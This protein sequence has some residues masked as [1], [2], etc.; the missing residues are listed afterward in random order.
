MLGALLTL[1]Q[2]VLRLQR[3][4]LLALRAHAFWLLRLQLLH[5]LLQAIDAVLTLRRLARKHLALPL[6]NNLLSL[7]DVLLTLLRT[8]LL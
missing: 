3:P 1:E 7:L 5:A 2:A 6:L 4:L 8:L